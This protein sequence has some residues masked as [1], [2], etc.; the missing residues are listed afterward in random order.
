MYAPLLD[1]LVGMR[2]DDVMI[3]PLN[4][5][6]GLPART[7]L[8]APRPRITA[9]TAPAWAARWNRDVLNKG[10]LRRLGLVVTIIVGGLCMPPQRAQVSYL[11]RNRSERRPRER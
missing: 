10:D 11:D 9:R 1:A 3:C 6:S 2:F 4:T 7:V 5:S 8:A